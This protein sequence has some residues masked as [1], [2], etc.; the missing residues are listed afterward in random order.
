MIHKTIVKFYLTFYCIHWYW[1]MHLILLKW[2]VITKF[3]SE[4]NEYF[5][6]F[7]LIEKYWNG[8]TF[9]KSKTR[10]RFWLRIKFE[11]SQ[12]YLTIDQILWL[13]S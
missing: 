7:W 9:E 1:K 12:K 6:Y 11:R 5:N 3:F 8:Q 4:L 10:N 2:D 13:T